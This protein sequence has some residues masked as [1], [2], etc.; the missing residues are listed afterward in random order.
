MTGHILMPMPKAAVNKDYQVVPWKYEIGRSGQI[1]TMKTEAKSYPMGGSAY[2]S[3]GF[4]VGRPNF[5]Y[6]LAAIR[7]LN[8]SITRLASVPLLD[9]TAPTD[10]IVTVVTPP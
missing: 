8:R 10:Q 9:L 4:R 7:R 3:F 1:A 2:D 5:R 6:H